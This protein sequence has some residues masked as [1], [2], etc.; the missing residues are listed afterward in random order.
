MLNKLCILI[1]IKSKFINAKKNLCF[2]FKID[3]KFYKTT[4]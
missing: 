1:A 2:D 4:H 3:F